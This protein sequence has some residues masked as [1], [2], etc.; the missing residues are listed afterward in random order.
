ML[1][2]KLLIELI[3]GKV[4]C[5]C[6]IREIH[7]EKIVTLIHVKEFVVAFCPFKADFCR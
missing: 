6:K 1:R 3:K 7:I 4:G 2:Q 5:P